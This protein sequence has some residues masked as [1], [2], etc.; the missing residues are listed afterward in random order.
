MGNQ[1][2]VV[3]AEQSAI[4]GDEVQEV[5]HLLEVRRDV[6]VIPPEMRVVKLDINHMVNVAFR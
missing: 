4:A 3:I 2:G 5:R 6:W 1:G